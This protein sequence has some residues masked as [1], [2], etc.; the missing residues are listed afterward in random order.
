L[1]IV[2]KLVGDEA[3]EGLRG[4]LLAQYCTPL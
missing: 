2:K 3:Y 4:G 1:A